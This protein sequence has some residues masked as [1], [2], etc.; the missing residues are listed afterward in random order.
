M[1]PDDPG[2]PKVQLSIRA[3]RAIFAGGFQSASSAA[4]AGRTDSALCQINP[5]EFISTIFLQICRLRRRHERRQGLQHGL[6]FGGQ[7]QL[8]GM[9][10]ECRRVALPQAGCNRARIAR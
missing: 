2:R 7:S 5:F 8:V 9:V 10:L 6:F 1:G 3:K 4:T